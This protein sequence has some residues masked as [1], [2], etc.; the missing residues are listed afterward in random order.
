MGEEGGGCEG[1]GLGTTHEM[2][3]Y[4]GP[5]GWIFYPDST[6]YTRE[7]VLWKEDVEIRQHTYSRVVSE[8]ANAVETLGECPVDEANLWD[9]FSDLSYVIVLPLILA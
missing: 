8:D 6:G 9:N 5:N 4:V 2:I 7:E 3:Y 1:R